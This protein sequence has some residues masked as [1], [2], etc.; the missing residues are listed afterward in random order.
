MI[1]E[2]LRILCI[3]RLLVDYAT[4]RTILRPPTDLRLVLIYCYML[5]LIFLKILQTTLH[6][7]WRYFFY[8]HYLS[9]LYYLSCLPKNSF[10]TFLCN[11]NLLVEVHLCPAVPTHEKTAALTAISKSASC[12]TVDRRGIMY[13]CI[14]AHEELIISRRYM[15]R[16]MHCYRQ[17]PIEIFRISAEL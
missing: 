13:T 17:A 9:R 7:A 14:N 10:F 12:A 2:L 4:V 8:L 1:L 5:F 6:F 15:Y 16:S 3:C 11:I